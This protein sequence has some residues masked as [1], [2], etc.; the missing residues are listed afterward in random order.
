M[1]TQKAQS[2]IKTSTIAITI[3]SVLLAVAVAATVVLAAFAANRQATTTITFAGGISIEVT[4]ITT[5]GSGDTNYAWNATYNN[6][7]NTTGTIS[8][9]T[10]DVKLATI[11]IENTTTGDAPIWIIAKA[12]VTGLTSNPTITPATG[13]VAFGDAGWY[14][15]GS[16]AST[17]TN[18]TTDAV[19]FI[20][21]EV[22]VALEE[23]ATATAVVDVYAVSAYSTTAMNDLT[24]KA[25]A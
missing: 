6:Q 10:A 1:T 8:N 21:Q 7:S 20:A 25:A 3:L 13:W 14:L 24:T 23:G 19:P 18:V 2:K 17:A 9:A 11:S 12:G 16:D 22:T 15:Y 5:K 4:G